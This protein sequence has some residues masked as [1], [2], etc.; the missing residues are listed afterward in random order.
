MVM[1]VHLQ[2][3]MSQGFL[4]VMEL[5]VRHMPQDRLSPMPAEGYIVSIMAFY[6]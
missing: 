1:H 3:L 5:T 2:N 4:T 6:E